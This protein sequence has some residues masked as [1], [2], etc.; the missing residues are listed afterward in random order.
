MKG[1]SPLV[2]LVLTVAL[3]TV[4]VAITLTVIIPTMDRI[5]DSNVINEALENLELIND[6]VR[7]VASES[8]GSKR[9]ISVEVTDGFYRIDK[10]QEIIYFE[11]EPKTDFIIE[12]RIGNV[13][14]E[15]AP[16]FLEYFN[17]YTSGTNASP[18]WE[19]INGTCEVDSGMYY[20]NKGTAYAN[21]TS[22]TQDFTI[23]GEIIDRSGKG[24]IYSLVT[25]PENL[26]LYL[27]MDEGDGSITYDYSGH[28]NDGD[29]YGNTR[30]LLHLD[31]GSGQYAYDLSAYGNDGLLGN[32]TASYFDPTWVSSCVSGYCLEFDGVDDYLNISDSSSLDI[33]QEITLE[34][35]VN[36]QASG[37]DFQSIITK[38]ES[39][40]LSTQLF[41]YNMR[42]R[43]IGRPSCSINTSANGWVYIEG[44]DILNNNT[45]YHI[46]CVYDGSAFTIYVDGANVSSTAASGTISVSTYPVLIG[47]I[48][49][50][51][52][53]GYIDEVAIYSKALS[54]SEIQELYYA[55]KA[56]FV[57]WVDGK[58]GKAF[59]FDGMDDYVELPQGFYDP[60][61]TTFEFW[62]Y[63][64][65]YR[66][67]KAHIGGDFLDE[68]NRGFDFLFVDSNRVR[69][70]LKGGWFD[71]PTDS[72]TW[73]EWFHVVVTASAM[74]GKINV[75]INGE[76]V[77]D[78]S[79]T[80][81]VS[82]Q[83]H[84]YRLGRRGY[85]E[86]YWN[87]IIDE[88]KVYNKSLSE[89]EVKAMYELGLKRLLSS[90]STSLID[91]KEKIYLVVS[92]P[93]GK[94]Y[95]DNIKVKTIEKKMKLIVPFEK[96]DFTSSLRIGKGNFKVSVENKGLNEENKPKIEIKII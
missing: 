8:E 68:A 78:Y 58:V 43:K 83:A 53:D 30:L 90:G 14:L 67:G 87:G 59:E 79:T 20:C 29:H 10:D 41:S 31:E 13:Y 25:N 55:K 64:D 2:G 1:I 16:V 48:G 88:V 4:A 63:Q 38:A 84:P 5:R 61:E 45:W 56:K 26:V 27:T 86:E 72:V 54:A 69:V 52:F 3:S 92:N 40:T 93:Y 42:L 17:N 49:D 44:P 34:A 75:Y 28:D 7:Q 85:V 21:V 96:T 19:I 6:V 81:P 66:G 91:H 18:I 32:D 24:E 12:G 11:Y 36:T 9:S 71:T 77:A 15:R 23:H 57:D 94:S 74:T 50:D 76:W 80:F 62:V 37:I 47:G 46:A 60:N 65:S 70:E 73:G 33:T 22:I 95:F 82:A 51:E 89:E 39:Q 35:W